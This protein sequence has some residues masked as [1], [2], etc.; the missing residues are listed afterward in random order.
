M[1][2]RKIPQILLLGNGIN[3][4]YNGDSWDGL[5]KEISGDPDFKSL[6][7]MPQQIVVATGNDVN[8]SL[9]KYKNRLFGEIDDDGHRDI[10]R[11][12]LAA[13]FD[14]ILTTNY[15]YELEIA[16]IDR[17]K[18]SEYSLGKMKDTTFKGKRAEAKYMLH[19]F[20][21]VNYLSAHNRVWHIHG[22]ARNH[23]SMVI[24]HYYYCNLVSKIKLYFDSIGNRYEFNQSHNNDIEINSWL[25][26]FVLGDVYTIG[27][28]FDPSEVDLWWLL[29]R[30]HL[31]RAKKGKVYYYCPSWEIT[32]SKNNDKHALLNCHNVEISGRNI[33]CKQGDYKEFY[34]KALQEIRNRINQYDQI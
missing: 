29:E 22:E 21:S 20:N 23:S 10:L 17:G 30:K 5:I 32:D 33:V 8:E 11:S 2:D 1:R 31:E 12:I 15:S 9:K 3:R 7:P 27:F 4:S 16:A 28:G 34:N 26:A 14:E 18:I 25:D 13:E 19:T 24:G 6:L